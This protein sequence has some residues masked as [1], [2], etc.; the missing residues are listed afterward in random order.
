MEEAFKILDYDQNGTFEYNDIF[1]FIKDCVRAQ[2]KN[3]LLDGAGKKFNVKNQ[4]KNVIGNDIYD[5]YAPMIDVSIDFIYSEF[6]QKK[7][8]CFKCL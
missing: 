7:I 1:E 3:K 8:K 6:F 2:T 5:R 4:V